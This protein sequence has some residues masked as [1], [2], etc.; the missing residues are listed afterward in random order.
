MRPKRFLTH[1]D[2]FAACAKL[3]TDCGFRDDDDSVTAVYGVPRGGIPVAYLLKGLV[4]SACRLVDRPER[5]TLIVDDV[6]DSGATRQRHLDNPE[7]KVPGRFVALASY[8]F[9]PKQP[10]EWIVFPWEQG[11]GGADTSA[12]DIVTRLLEVIGEDPTREGLKE[13]PRRVLAAWKEWSSG[14][15]K[16]PKEILKSFADGRERYDEMVVVKDLPFY[17]MCEH[18]LAPF[19]GTA[20]I[21]Y[22][23]ERSI[24][25]LSKL[26]RVLEIFARRLQVQ[27]RLTTQVADALQDNLAPKG[28]GVLVKA[29]HLCMESRGYARQGHET[30][31]SALRGVFLKPEVRAE[32]LSL[33]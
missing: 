8:L 16:D 28:V 21:A 29:R 11:P 1:V 4:G 19:F 2:C 26:G 33:V 14:Y 9:P 31:T 22:I 12:D 17:S 27:E 25:G 23:P 32:F 30:V 10:D 20:S 7:W 5:A 13:T 15:G 24:V 3:A 6:I 18:H